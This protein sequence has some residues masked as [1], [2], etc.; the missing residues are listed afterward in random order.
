MH[1]ANIAVLIIYISSSDTWVYQRTLQKKKYHNTENG[2][3]QIAFTK[4][5]LVCESSFANTSNFNIYNSVI[6]HI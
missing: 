5:R 2:Q 4:S 3:R 6:L 1:Y